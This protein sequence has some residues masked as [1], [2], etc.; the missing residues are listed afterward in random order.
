MV[1]PTINF[2]LLQVYPVETSGNSKL[3]P[4]WIG[5]SQ[6]NRDHITWTLPWLPVCFE[7]G[8]LN[9]SS[10]RLTLALTPTDEIAE[11]YEQFDLGIIRAASAE[12]VKIFGRLMSPEEVTLNYCSNLARS[13]H[14]QSIRCKIKQRSEQVERGTNFWSSSGLL[15]ASYWP[16][17][18]VGQEV[19]AKIVASSIWIA[20]SKWGVCL[21]ASDIKIRPNSTTPPPS[22]RC[23]FDESEEELQEET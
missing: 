16:E 19:M 9:E 17:K 15:P 10:K 6:L 12:S 21:T 4:I 11:W 13:N 18:W 22:P 8:T 1:P 3:A 14:L 23:P 2:S 7:P 20:N 5:P